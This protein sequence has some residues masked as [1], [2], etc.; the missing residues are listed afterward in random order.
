M[1]NSELETKVNDAIVK[2]ITDDD[3]F[4]PHTRTERIDALAKTKDAV[5][6][7]LQHERDPSWQRGSRN[8]PIRAT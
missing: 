3:S 8:N 5:T 2:A 7:A 6:R 4:S 1:T